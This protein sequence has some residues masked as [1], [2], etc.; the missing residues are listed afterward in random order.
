MQEHN[1]VLG[2]RSCGEGAP[3][4]AAIDGNTNLNCRPVVKS[5]EDHDPLNLTSAEMASLWATK[6]STKA[7][8]DQEVL[9]VGSETTNSSSVLACSR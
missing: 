7:A 4:R 6:M 2:T 3:P 5:K 8:Q 9:V 1:Q